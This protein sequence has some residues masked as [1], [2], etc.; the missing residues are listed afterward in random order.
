MSVAIIC[1]TFKDTN[2]EPAHQ[3]S[4]VL[5]VLLENLSFAVAIIQVSVDHWLTEE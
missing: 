4:S 2:A 3:F 1:K 5:F